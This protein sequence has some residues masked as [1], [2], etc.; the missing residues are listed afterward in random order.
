MKKILFLVFASV[1]WFA[2]GGAQTATVTSSSSVL[3]SAG[4]QLTLTATIT[5]PTGTNIVTGVAVTNGGSGYTSV[6][7]VSFKPYPVTGTGTGAAATATIDGRVASIAIVN[8]GSGY[9][10]PTVTLS[11]GGGTGALATATIN[12]GVIT[13]IAV[14]A[15]GTGYTSTPTVAITGQAGSGRPERRLSPKW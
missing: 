4:G 1:C 10:A 11:G 13:G 7:T 3:N 5:Y 9:T 6:P 2:R 14:T 12:G 8:G 15:A